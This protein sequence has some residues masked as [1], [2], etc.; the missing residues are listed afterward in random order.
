MQCVTSVISDKTNI[1]GVP[2][3]PQTPWGMH[4]SGNKMG[5]VPAF[6]EPVI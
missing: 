1:N 4:V 5:K 6:M 3:F 2:A